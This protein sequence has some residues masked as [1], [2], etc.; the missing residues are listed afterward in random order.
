MGKERQSQS[1]N[2]KMPLDAIGTLVVTKPF[3]FNAGIASVF[4]RLRINDE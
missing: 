3:R 2:S 4:Y 1:I